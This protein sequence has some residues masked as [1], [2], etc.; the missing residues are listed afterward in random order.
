M[1]RRELLK[2]AVV[3]PLAGI[4]VALPQRLSATQYEVKSASKYLLRINAPGASPLALPKTVQDSARK[5]QDQLRIDGLD[6]TVV[7]GDFD[8]FEMDC[9]EIPGL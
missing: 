7:V 4:A 5:L 8:L 2:K 1:N 3:A 9:R 6:V